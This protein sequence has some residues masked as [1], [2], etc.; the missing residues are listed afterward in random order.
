M[1]EGRQREV[2]VFVSDG[3]NSRLSDF[4]GEVGRQGE[5]EQLRSQAGLAAGV[6]NLW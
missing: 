3:R 6:E 5:G 4:A 1:R 2:T